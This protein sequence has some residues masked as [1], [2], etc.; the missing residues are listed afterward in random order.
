MRAPL[1]H[2]IHSGL[3][4]HNSISIRKNNTRSKRQVLENMKKLRPFTFDFLLNYKPMTNEQCLLK[5]KS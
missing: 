2:T 5:S 1:T 4:Y 3:C